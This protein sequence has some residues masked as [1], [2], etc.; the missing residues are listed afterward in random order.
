[1]SAFSGCSNLLSVTL[2][3]GVTSIGDHAFAGCLALVGA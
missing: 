2:G 1:M 3:R